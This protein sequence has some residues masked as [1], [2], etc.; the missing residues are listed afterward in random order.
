[1]K[2]VAPPDV[3]AQ[4]TLASGINGLAWYA[5]TISGVLWLAATVLGCREDPAP[6]RDAETQ[7]AATARVQG[8]GA[9]IPTG[10]L[11]WFE[12]QIATA[13]FSPERTEPDPLNLRYAVVPAQ[14][15]L[16]GVDGAVVAVELDDGKRAVALSDLERWIRETDVISIVPEAPS[17]CFPPGQAGAGLH[18]RFRFAGGWSWQAYYSGTVPDQV[19]QLVERCRT[20]ARSLRDHGGADLPADGALKKFDGAGK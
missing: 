11:T 3:T 8:T 19:R 1:M 12:L 9:T 13:P 20:H 6:P 14:P 15:L 18:L 7:P 17:K 2:K 10:A 5:V 16:V 4:V